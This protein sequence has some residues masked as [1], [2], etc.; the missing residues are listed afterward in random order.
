MDRELFFLAFI[1][2]FQEWEAK[3][4]ALKG[5]SWGTFKS[6]IQGFGPS[7]FS[8]Q[9]PLQAICPDH[10]LQTP[11]QRSGIRNEEME[12]VHVTVV[13]FHLRAS[14]FLEESQDPSCCTGSFNSRLLP[15][16]AAHGL[17]CVVFLPDGPE[18]HQTSGVK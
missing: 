9:Y 14:P 1:H 10:N 17:D 7:T 16:L 15:C 4:G 6:Q 18:M 13:I 2:S 5:N 8:S 12:L 11:R 3:Y